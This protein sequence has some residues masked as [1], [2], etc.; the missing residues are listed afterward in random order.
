VGTQGV[1]LVVAALVFLAGLGLAVGYPIMAK[2]LPHMPIGTWP[3]YAPL[4]GF[5]TFDTPLKPDDA[6]VQIYLDL[7]SAGA[8]KFGK[9][10]AV[11]TLTVS[12]DGKTVLAAPLTFEDAVARDDTPQTPELVYRTSAGVIDP[13]DAATPAYRFTTGMGDAEGI[14]IAKVDLVLQHIPPKADPRAQPIGFTLMAMGFIGFVLML[15][16]KGGGTPPDPNSQ[17]PPRWGRRAR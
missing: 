6:P 17:P 11:L 10:S 13:V 7:T 3:V 4:T 1:R 2:N 16:G 12:A 5:L 14:D 9:D 8:P 15:R